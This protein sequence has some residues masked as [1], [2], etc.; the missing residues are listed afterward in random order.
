MWY[1]HIPTP[2][3]ACHHDGMLIAMKTTVD[4]A[5]RLV[6]PHELRSRIGLAA[7]GEV[8]LELDGAAVRI[9]PI[10]GSE[11][12]EEEGLLVVPTTGSTFGSALVRE[13]V[14]ADRHRHG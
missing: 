13:L 3:A 4:R 8:R 9:E 1:K 14:D 11:L 6:I 12:V 7:G 2:S 5:G 10:T